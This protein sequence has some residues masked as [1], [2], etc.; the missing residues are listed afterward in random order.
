VV[1]QP[2]KAAP[3]KTLNEIRDFLHYM[4]VSD[5]LAWDGS[6]SATLVSDDEVVVTP[7][8]RK[9]N[10]IPVGAVFRSK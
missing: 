10:T 6:D 2:H 7:G 3:G 1:V 5:A 4:G 8:R 9:N